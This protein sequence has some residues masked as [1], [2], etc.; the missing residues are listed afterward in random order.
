MCV[1]PSCQVF[2]FCPNMPAPVVTTVNF[3]SLFP[4]PRYPT[5]F[6][7]W[8]PIVCRRLRLAFDLLAGYLSL[9]GFDARAALDARLPT[10]ISC[11][12][13]AL[14]FDQNFNVQVTSTGFFFS[15]NRFSSAFR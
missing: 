2:S 3:S 11:L 6:G 4:F 9:L 10:V 13:E 15:E 14:E 8:K 1:R 5:A 7:Q 12:C